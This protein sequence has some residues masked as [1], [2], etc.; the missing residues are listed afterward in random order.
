MVERIIFIHEK[1]KHSQYIHSTTLFANE[2]A[3]INYLFIFSGLDF[4]NV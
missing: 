4:I 1:H 2:I 3:L